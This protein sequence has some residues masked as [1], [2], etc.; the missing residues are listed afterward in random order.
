[1]SRAGLWRPTLG[2]SLAALLVACT[3]QAPPNFDRLNRATVLIEHL[4]GHGTGIIVGPNHVLTAYHVVTSGPLAVVFYQGPAV[5]GRVH[6]YDQKLDLALVE[7]EV[8]ERY[9]ATE[10]ACD[11]LRIGQH[12]V[13]VGHPMRARWVAADGRLPTVTAVGG[14]GLVPL[15]FDIGLGSSGGP[16]FDERGR[17]AGIALAILAERRSTSAGYDEFKDTGMGLM[18]PASAFCNALQPG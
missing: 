17:L 16:V 18:L 4:K 10:L 1:M 14:L 13:A 3:L 6:W 5:G 8:P 12:L 7:V 11:Q 9:R 15:G 2:L